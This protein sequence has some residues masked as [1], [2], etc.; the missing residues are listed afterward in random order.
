MDHSSPGSSVGFSRCGYWSGLPCP[1]PGDLDL[2]LELTSLKS[3]ELPGRFFATRVNSVMSSGYTASSGSL[4]IS[5]TYKVTSS[6]EVLKSSKSFM[7][8]GISYFQTP[9]NVNLL[10]SSHE[11]QMFLMAF[12][13]INTFQ[14]IFNLACQDP[15]E[16]LRICHYLWQPYKK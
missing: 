12:R 6:T 16:D 10:M 2:G 9:I 15:S 1:P 7:K 8:V 3:P 13:V 4:A 14:K 5:T 11:S